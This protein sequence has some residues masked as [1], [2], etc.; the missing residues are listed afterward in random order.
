ME[1]RIS[2]RYQLSIYDEIEFMV[3][4]G[5]SKCGKRLLHFD[6][7]GIGIASGTAM[8][9]NAEPIAALCAGCIAEFREV[10]GSN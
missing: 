7:D 1:N 8:F 9:R 4:T 6:K 2:E 3:C 10:S 5:C